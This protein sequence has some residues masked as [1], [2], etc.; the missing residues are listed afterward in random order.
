MSDIANPEVRSLEAHVS[1]GVQ[2]EAF[3]EGPIGKMFVK[4]VEAERS[5]ALERLAGVD[6]DD[7]RAVRA[8]QTEIRVI[9]TVQQYLADTLTA[10]EASLA[11]LEQFDHGD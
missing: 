3:L 1:L 8:I 5:A 2:V 4:R 10:A 6:P 9:D 11:R 7:S